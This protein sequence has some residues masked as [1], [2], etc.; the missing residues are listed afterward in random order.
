M[1]EAEIGVIKPVSLGMRVASRIPPG[2]ESKE[3]PK[4][5]T[6]LQSR[7]K[8]RVVLPSGCHSGEWG[9]GSRISLGRSS[10]GEEKGE[11]I[12]ARRTPWAFRLELR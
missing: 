6:W 4:S 11:K 10:M 1:R 7:P 5:G 3:V 2:G 9:R 8:A 12:L